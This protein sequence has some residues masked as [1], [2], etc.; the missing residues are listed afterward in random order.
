MISHIASSRHVV[1]GYLSLTKPRI[2]VL[3]LFT[4]LAGM[5]LASEGN[6][7]PTIVILVLAGGA[8]AAGGA[9]AL[10]HFFDKDIDVLMKR[11]RGRPVT[12]GRISS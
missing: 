10:N 6:P 5:F 8:M 2:L 1:S 7:N 9:H 12:S 4:A 11:T 3:L